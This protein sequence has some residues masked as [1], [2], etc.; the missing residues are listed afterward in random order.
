MMGRA[1]IGNPWVFRE[2][3]H[4]LETG[5][6]LPPPS[7]DERVE[8]C[9]KHLLR[10]LKWKGE[11][12]GILEM[13]RHYYNYLKGLPNIKEYRRILVTSREKEVLLDTLDEIQK[14]Y[15]GFEFEETAIIPTLI[16]Q[17]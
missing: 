4:F 6:T 9:R 17:E 2:I 3:R 12:V 5:E 10:S 13:R 11:I 16:K 14:H 7:V 1:T 15:A 8:A